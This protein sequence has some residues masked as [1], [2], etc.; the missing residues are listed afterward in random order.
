MTDPIPSAW[1]D[2]GRAYADA[3]VAELDRAP[4]H[5]DGWA[6]YGGL[7]LPEETIEVV[8]RWPEERYVLQYRSMLGELVAAKQFPIDSFPEVTVLGLIDEGELSELRS[9]AS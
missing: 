4:L 1:T 2:P 6:H 8:G 7:V 3:M 5:F 9:L